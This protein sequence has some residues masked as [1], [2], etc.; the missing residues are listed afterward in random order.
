MGYRVCLEAAARSFVVPG[1]AAGRRNAGRL[2]G[3]GCKKTRF[4]RQSLPMPLGGSRETASETPLE[5]IGRA[6]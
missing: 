1:R 4:P 3:K 6:E 5:C 2:G